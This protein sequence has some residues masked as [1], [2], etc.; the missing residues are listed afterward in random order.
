MPSSSRIL[1]G[2]E[3]KGW[4]T[5]YPRLEESISFPDE[6]VGLVL[7]DGET[8][9]APAVP[10]LPTREEIEKE[11]QSILQ[12]ARRE[13]EAQ[14]LQLLDKTR[15]E[16][17]KLRE[18]ARQDGHTQ[19]LLAGEQDAEKLRAEARAVLEDAHRQKEEI[20]TGAEPE[21]IRIAVSLAEKLINYQLTVDAELIISLISG[22]LESLPSGEE[23]TIR[24]SPRDEAVCREKA[25]FIRSELKKGA[26]LRIIADEDLKPG[27]CRI[28]TEESEVTFILTRELQA[29]TGKLLQL[30]KNN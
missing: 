25:E 5:Y 10:P 27:S 9:A 30:S 26:S 6:D 16:A 22:C 28:E 21:I 17:D 1:R 13:S 29:L 24:V 19:G 18:K 11:R 14:C 20:L 3:I 23:V 7:P 12:Q 2:L 8:T 4:M 15:A